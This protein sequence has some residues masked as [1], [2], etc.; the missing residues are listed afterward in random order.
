MVLNLTI[1]LCGDALFTMRAY[2]FALSRLSLGVIILQ[3]IICIYFGANVE[4]INT[5]LDVLIG[6]IQQP[7][8]PA[9]LQSVLLNVT[10]QLRTIQQKNKEHGW[11]LI[12]V[13]TLGLIHICCAYSLYIYFLYMGYTWTKIA[14]HLNNL[15]LAVVFPLHFGLTWVVAYVVGTRLFKHLCVIKSFDR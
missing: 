3:A 13:I 4:K 15:L 8:L 6:N 11:L 9:P 7:R 14:L 1:Y 2:Y 10:Q 5:K 12:S